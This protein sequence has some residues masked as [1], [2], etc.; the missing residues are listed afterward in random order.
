MRLT[1][2]SA[3]FWFSLDQIGKW[4]VLYRMDLLSLREL[5]LWPPY[6]TFRMGWN[7][8]I[9]FGLLSGSAEATRWLLV[10][11]A[12]VISAWILA[13]SRKMERRISMLSAGAIVGGAIANAFDRVIYGAVA[14]F[15]NITC[16]GFDN[17]YAFNPADIGIFVGA[18]GLLIFADA[19]KITP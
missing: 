5:E 1:L 3:L 4:L 8:G 19:N 11:L 10:A 9:N 2:L 7:T 12:F 14:D 16:C 6:I 18:F 13:W 17:P 15:L